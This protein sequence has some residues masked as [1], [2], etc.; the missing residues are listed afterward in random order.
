MRY[1]EWIDNQHLEGCVQYVFDK[2][3]LAKKKAETD[4]DR[5]VID[6]FS[7]LFEMSGFDIDTV[8]Q[9]KKLEKIRQAQKSL[10]NHFGLFHQKLL[11]CID[12]W[13]DLG[14]GKNIDLLNE[15]KRI[16]AEVKN[17]FNT[18]KGS[19]QAGLYDSLYE[20]VMPNASEY[21]NFT[22]YYVEII[23][24]PFQGSADVYDKP[25]TPPDRT[26]SSKKPENKLIRKIDGKSFYT[27]VTGHPD[28]LQDLYFVL[29]KIN[30]KV[31]N[32]N[33]SDDEQRKINAYFDKAF[34]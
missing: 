4:F 14:T 24:K 20:L 23:P 25:F 15:E 9:W 13:K 29:P 12:G 6:P 3:I 18:M 30:Q 11:G 28:A 10:A 21:K 16:I 5:N 31:G 1:L 17:K 8:E 27:L 26:T 7:L 19:D 32:Y 22:A 33:F 34:V 2:A